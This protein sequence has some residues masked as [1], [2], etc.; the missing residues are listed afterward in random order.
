M[1]KKNNQ[2]FTFTEN[3]GKQFATTN[4]SLLDLFAT[5]GAMR[6]KT[7]AYITLAFQ[8]AFEENPLLATRMVFYARNIQAA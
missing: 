1:K 2:N 3:G 6:D 7:D 8:K 5:I 4:S